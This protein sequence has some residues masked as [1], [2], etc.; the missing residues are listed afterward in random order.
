M[1]LV[2]IFKAFSVAEA[3]LT[4]ARLE[5][6]GFHAVVIGKLAALSMEGYSQATGGI[7]VQ[8]LESEAAEARAF[9]DADDT[10][11]GSAE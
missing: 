2:T 7:R 5:A 9:L 10:P 8:V 11:A 6:N 3:E 4:R 1:T